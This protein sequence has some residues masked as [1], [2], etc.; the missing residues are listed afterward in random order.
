MKVKTF[1]KNLTI[2]GE[3]GYA[4]ENEFECPKFV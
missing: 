2:T 1:Y 3:G 4:Q